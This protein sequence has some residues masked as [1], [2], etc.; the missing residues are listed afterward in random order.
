MKIPM[1]LRT[2]ALL[3]GTAPATTGCVGYLI[4]YSIDL[5]NKEVIT[6]SGSSAPALETG[7]NVTVFLNSGEKIRGKYRGLEQLSEERYA[8]SYSE[9]RDSL[10]GYIQL[11]AL[12]D[13]VDL[14]R[15]SGDTLKAEFLG[16]NHNGVVARPIGEADI[17][18]VEAGA[19]RE[20]LG[21]G[22]ARVSNV[23][24]KLLATEGRL[25]IRSALAL[26][27]YGETQLVP[28]NK[29]ARIERTPTK[30]RWIG[31]AVEAAITA[32]YIAIMAATW[33]FNTSW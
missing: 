30:G 3:V 10:M 24:L 33:E 18:G 27:R 32:A 15:Y 11:P 1:V 25:P 12:G 21:D 16:L 22:H 8:E 13:T 26:E 4:G 17:R 6:P 29:V 2:L 19:V 9:S 23:E 14:L 28:L 5:G 20:V 7:K 31:F